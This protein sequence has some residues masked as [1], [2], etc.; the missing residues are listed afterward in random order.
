MSTNYRISYIKG[1]KNAKIH[2]FFAIFF[3]PFSKYLA[4]SGAKYCEKGGPLQKLARVDRQ[5][6][7][8]TFNFWVKL[9][10][11][12]F[13][14]I[15]SRIIWIFAGLQGGC[16]SSRLFHGFP[17][18]DDISLFHHSQ[19]CNLLRKYVFCCCQVLNKSMTVIFIIPC[20]MTS[21]SSWASTL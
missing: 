21:P 3:R 14:T 5:T 19:V 12:L 8:E 6:H 1:S 11:L 18:P 16:A 20:P 10:F 4:P 7:F 17:R 15:F 9:L 2:R 13:L